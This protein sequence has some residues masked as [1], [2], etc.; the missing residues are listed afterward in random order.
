LARG[1]PF[2]VLA[3]VIEGVVTNCQLL[4]RKTLELLHRGKIYLDSS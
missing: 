3:D 1:S 4:V 2:T